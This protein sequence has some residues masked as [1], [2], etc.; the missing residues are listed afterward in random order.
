MDV[1]AAWNGHTYPFFY[2]TS[3]IGV[4]LPP[5]SPT[6]KDAVEM[7]IESM[8]LMMKHLPSGG[9]V[10]P[11][12]LGTNWADWSNALEREMYLWRALAK[13]NLE[14]PYELEV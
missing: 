1:E 13:L 11:P 9:E 7:L 10:S 4:P 5:P 3:K 2:N 8:S 6:S 14:L 12:P